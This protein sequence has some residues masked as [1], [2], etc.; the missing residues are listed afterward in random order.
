MKWIELIIDK[1]LSARFLITVAIGFTY[2]HIVWHAVHFYLKAM[3][4]DPKQ[5]E[6]FATGLIMGFTGIATFIFKAYFD[7]ADR[8][9]AVDPAK[10][11]LEHPK[12]PG[13]QTTAIQDSSKGNALTNLLILSALAIFSVGC[14]S[15]GINGMCGRITGQE[16]TVP[17]V[18]GKANVDGYACHVGCVGLGCPKPSYDAI[19]SVMDAY[20]KMETTQGKIMTTGPGTVVFTP[21]K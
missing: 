8:P 1:V 7:R 15:A 19:V 9:V 2:C 3:T 17:Y 13:T 5:M 11:V 20:S 21:S 16:M 12:A 6:A 14:A 10:P 4:S 18:S